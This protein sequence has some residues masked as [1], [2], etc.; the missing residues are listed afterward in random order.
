[1]S[2]TLLGIAKDLELNDPSGLERRMALGFR[3]AGGA[4]KGL[5]DWARRQ[6]GIKDLLVD[7]VQEHEEEI[8][9]LTER[10]EQ[11]ETKPK[12]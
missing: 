4:I 8:R 12:K 11:L 1:M 10:I 7:R 5:R 9:N 3:E 6:K 2:E